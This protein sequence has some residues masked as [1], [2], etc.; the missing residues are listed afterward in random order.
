MVEGAPKTE[1]SLKDI[2]LDSQTAERLWAWKSRS[3]YPALGDWVFASPHMKGKQPYWPG[4][5]WR[6]YAKPALL[7]RAGIVKHVSDHTFRHTFGTLLNANGE[8]LKVVQGVAPP[9]EP[10]GH[11]GHLHAG[12]RAPETEAQSNLVRLVRKG[13]AS[14]AASG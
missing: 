6:Y 8:N 1:A 10:E 12:R 11:D 4:P 14:E 13:A 5:L 2:P 7:K 9:R 3:P